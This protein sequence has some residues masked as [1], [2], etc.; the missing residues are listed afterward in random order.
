M[1][2]FAAVNSKQDKGCTALGRRSHDFEIKYSS[3]TTRCHGPSQMPT[4]DLC[5]LRENGGI[6]GMTHPGPVAR[7]HP[8]VQQSS[9]DSI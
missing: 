8:L 2:V 4:L 3:E 9:P 5:L 6:D 1:S 7:A